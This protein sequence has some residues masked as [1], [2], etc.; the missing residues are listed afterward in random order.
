MS[1]NHAEKHMV[2]YHVTLIGS[3]KNDS[4]AEA[5]MQ[6]NFEGYDEDGDYV[7]FRLALKNLAMCWRKPSDACQNY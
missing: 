1:R 4:E 5:Y 7:D 2:D 6:V 3:L